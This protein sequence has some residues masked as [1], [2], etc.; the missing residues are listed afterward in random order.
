METE[1]PSVDKLSFCKPAAN[2]GAASLLC[3]HIS[4]EAAPRLKEEQKISQP[5]LQTYRNANKHPFL[6]LKS[7]KDTNNIYLKQWLYM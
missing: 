4:R 2:T 3:Y 6:L 1:A 7:F 5:Y